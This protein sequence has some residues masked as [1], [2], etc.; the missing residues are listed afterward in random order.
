[1]RELEKVRRYAKALAEAPHE[2]LLVLDAT[3]GPSTVQQAKVFGESMGITGIVLTDS[4]AA[5][6][7]DHQ[8]EQLAASRYIG[9]GE[10]MEDLQ[11]FEPDGFVKLS[12]VICRR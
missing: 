7:G 12:L 3:A 5:R 2:T 1:M 9:V 10:Q 8:R 6:G 4:M 11:P